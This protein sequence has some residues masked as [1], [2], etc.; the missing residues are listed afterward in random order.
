MWS[1]VCECLSDCVS[2][3]GSS[4][5]NLNAVITDPNC[6]PVWQ[7]APEEPKSSPTWVLWHAEPEGRHAAA[8][9][10]RVYDERPH[11]HC[12]TVCEHRADICSDDKCFCITNTRH[13]IIINHTHILSSL[14]RSTRDLAHC[15]ALTYL[16]RQPP[17][18]VIPWFPSI[19]YSLSLSSF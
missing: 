1:V 6:S 11:S 12:G 15:R 4:V 17:S 2:K 3:Q 18:T 16:Q 10:S 14:W 8:A 7:R 5:S 19:I 9:A 13:H